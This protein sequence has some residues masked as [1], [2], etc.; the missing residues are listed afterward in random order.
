MT[1][2]DELRHILDPIQCVFGGEYGAGPFLK[3][4][5]TLKVMVNIESQ[6]DE[7]ADRYLE[8]FRTVAAFCRVM[9]REHHPDFIGLSKEKLLAQRPD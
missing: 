9:S 3:A 8:A 5:S 1:T 4:L 7:N 2:A 6:G